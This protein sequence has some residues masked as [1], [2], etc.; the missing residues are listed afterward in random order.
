MHGSIR[1]NLQK[2]DTW[3]VWKTEVI[4]LVSSKDTDEKQLMH[5]NNILSLMIK[6]MKLLKNISNHLF[7]YI[8]LAKKQLWK[9]RSDKKNGVKSNKKTNKTAIKSNAKIFPI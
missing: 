6:Q 8:K 1:N 2:Y 3:K 7:L 4:N 5:L 9:V